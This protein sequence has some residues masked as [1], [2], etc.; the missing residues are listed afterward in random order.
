MIKRQLEQL[1]V[2]I[3]QFNHAYSARFRVFFAFM[4]Y[5][6]VAIV[7]RNH[8]QD[9]T[10]RSSLV[11][12]FLKRN[13]WMHKKSLA[14]ANKH[15][16]FQATSCTFTFLSFPCFP[17][18]RAAKS[19]IH[20]KTSISQDLLWREEE[21]GIF[22]N[23]LYKGKWTEISVIC[24]GSDGYAAFPED[25]TTFE[26]GHDDKILRYFPTLIE[27]KK[28]A[29]NYFNT[30]VKQRNYSTIH[31]V[32]LLLSKC[33]SRIVAPCKNVY[34]TVQLLQALV[35]CYWLYCHSFKRAV[36]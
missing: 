17:F 20:N 11:S 32:L 4:S 31:R 6:Q 16:K 19:S 18:G 27:A 5:F 33:R 24:H 23:L 22:H 10:I 28:Y 21:Q 36:R 7:G 14:F 9:D 3:G 30:Q 1:T 12:T 29:E 34:L 35:H 26:V 2:K 25:A 15:T 8:T 13:D